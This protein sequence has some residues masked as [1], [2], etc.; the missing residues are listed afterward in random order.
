MKSDLIFDV[1]M[2]KGEDTD[3][4]LKKGFNVVAIEANPEMVAAAAKRFHEEISN[5]KLKIYNL[6][7]AEEVSQIDFFINRD[8]D[9]WSL[10]FEHVGGRQGSNYEKITVVGAPLDK[11]IL[12]AGMPHY[13]KIDIE[14]ADHIALSKLQLFDSRPRFV[15]CEC[16]S[17]D[18]FL[19]LHSLGYTK[20][21][22]VNQRDLW[23]IKCENPPLEGKY[24]D[25]QF[26]GIHSGPFGEEAPGQWCSIEEAIY[27]WLHNKL[28]F[29]DRSLIGEGWYDVHAALD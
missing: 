2:H 10:I 12:D 8:K 24:V 4:Y 5:G 9:D 20:F 16:H 11:V 3:F 19:E 26:S 1:G 27:T 28:G 29:I 22:V 23:K 18:I 17:I 7:I 21:K 14:H 25:Q 13:M 15:S 6:A